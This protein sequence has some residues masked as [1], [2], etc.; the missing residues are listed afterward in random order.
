MG[1]APGTTRPGGADASTS[2]PSSPSAPPARLA[3]PRH[4]PA[5]PSRWS[6]D[7]G[8]ETCSAPFSRSWG[9][10]CR[11]H[12]HRRS[13]SA[14]RVAQQPA[15]AGARERI[16][17]RRNDHDVCFVAHLAGV[18]KPPRIRRP[19]IRA[20]TRWR[21][22]RTPHAPPPPRAISVVPLSCIPTAR[23]NRD[24]PGAPPSATSSFE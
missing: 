16:A 22:S 6:R 15:V 11:Y 1:V 14:Q 9:G 17:A 10:R 19:A 18:K 13:R 21:R 7:R 20:R 12:A 23:A 5:A 4:P 24:T 2:S 3:P 8:K